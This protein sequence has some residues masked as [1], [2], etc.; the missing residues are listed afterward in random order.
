MARM[1]R[2]K[3]ITS[4]ATRY[5]ISGVGL[6]LLRPPRIRQHRSFS[7]LSERRVMDT[8]GGHGLAREFDPNPK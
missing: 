2:I 4:V 3:V 1:T 7:V 5:T 6:H 8:G